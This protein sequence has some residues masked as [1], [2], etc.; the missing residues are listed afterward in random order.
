MP[1]YLL[2]GLLVVSQARGS[3]AKHSQRG[4]QVVPIGAGL[5]LDPAWRGIG[6]AFACP[7]LQAGVVN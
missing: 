6:F 1:A 3:I 7:S 5:N 2:P 4:Q